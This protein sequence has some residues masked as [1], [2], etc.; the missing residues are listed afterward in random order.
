[1]VATWKTA[2]GAT[3]SA[4]GVALTPDSG[5]FWFFDPTNVELTL[6]VLDACSLNSKFW[7]FL[8]GGTDVQVTLTVTDTQTGTVKILHQSVNHTF[9]TVTDT[10]AFGNCP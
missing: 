2:A 7:V 4:Q 10:S 1:M 3:G 6:K 5:Y 8:S 9:L